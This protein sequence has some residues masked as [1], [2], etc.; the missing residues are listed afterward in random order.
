MRTNSKLVKE[1]LVSINLNASSSI[2][3]ENTEFRF[4]KMEKAKQNVDAK[5]ILLEPLPS[6]EICAS[7]GFKRTISAA[8]IELM[9]KAKQNLK[10]KLGR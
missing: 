2:I 1:Y 8:D 5:L 9:E 3:N 4:D 7:P 10:K 6:R